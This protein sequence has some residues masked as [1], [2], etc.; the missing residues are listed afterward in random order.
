[1]YVAE[2]VIQ[3][4]NRY[5]S[6]NA[7]VAESLQEAEE[8]FHQFKYQQALETAAAAI[9]QVDPGSMKNLDANLEEVLL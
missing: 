6:N 5:R 3:Y 9:E 1:M 8:L 4:G 7:V 2:K